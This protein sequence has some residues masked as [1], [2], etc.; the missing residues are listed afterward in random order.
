MNV[1]I[2]KYFWDQVTNLL[3]NMFKGDINISMFSILMGY[4]IIDPDPLINSIILLD[5][6]FIYRCKASY[7]K[8]IFVLFKVL[9]YY[10]LQVENH[11]ALDRCNLLKQKWKYYKKWKDS[12]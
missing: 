8:P 4:N 11:I 3:D 5:K 7:S 9:L 2:I 6:Q 12:S 10:M 1:N